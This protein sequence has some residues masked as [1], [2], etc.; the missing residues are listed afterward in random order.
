[1]AVGDLP[2]PVVSTATATSTSA[3]VVALNGKRQRLRIENLSPQYDVYLNWGAN[4][5]VGQG[6]RLMGGGGFIDIHLT[7]PGGDDWAKDAVHAIVDGPTADL[8]I[9]ELSL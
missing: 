5:V 7:F 8:S 1:M 2:A 9:E 6:R 3:Q 4:A